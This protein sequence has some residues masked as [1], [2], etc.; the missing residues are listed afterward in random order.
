MKK[1]IEILREY[2]IREKESEATGKPIGL[3]EIEIKEINEA[4]IRLPLEII[5]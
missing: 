3:T 4:I 1:A 5:D 2:K